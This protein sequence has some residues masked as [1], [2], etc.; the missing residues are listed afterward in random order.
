MCMCFFGLYS[1]LVTEGGAL[2]PLKSRSNFA[3]NY[4]ESPVIHPRTVT[5]LTNNGLLES[6]HIRVEHYFLTFTFISHACNR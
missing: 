5:L 1:V 2:G 6:N 3:D 4:S